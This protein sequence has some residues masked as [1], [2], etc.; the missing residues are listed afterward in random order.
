MKV[1]LETRIGTLLEEADQLEEGP[2]KL[3][4]LEEAVRLADQQQHLELGDS[5]RGSLIRTATFSG[6]PEKALVAFSW[7]LAQSERDPQRFPED[8][9][10][11]E[12][13]WIT[14]SLTG[15]PQIT[16]RQIEE[17]LADMTR[18]YQ[19]SSSSLR[20]IH[21]LRC[22]IAMAMCEPALARKHHREWEKTPRDWNTDC[23]ACEQNHRVRFHAFI[24]KKEEAIDLAGPILRGTLRCAEVPHATY[25]L[26][27]LP[28]VHL[29]RIEEAMNYHQKGYPLIHTH[30]K[31]LDEVSCH[32]L[33]LTLTQNLPEAVHLFEKHLLWA[34]QTRDLYWRWNFY[35][36]AHFLLYRLGE[37]DTKTLKLR[38]PESL[39]VYQEGGRYEVGE[40]LG[41]VEGECRDLAKQ[42]DARNGNDGFTRRLANNRRMTRWICPF[43]IK[44]SRKSLEEE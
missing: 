27:L 35:L 10:L 24:G 1:D 23:P 26:V 32:L 7:R 18:R 5:I 42:F 25:A 22:Q 37:S 39:P 6:F 3:A 36:A 29:G 41:W 11:C 40:L 33:F 2:A 4:T 21:K 16:R 31:F 28:L 9:L 30:R 19:R 38:L 34:F 14:D 43:P 20:P 12:Y 8:E 44:R 13:K 15:F 17:M